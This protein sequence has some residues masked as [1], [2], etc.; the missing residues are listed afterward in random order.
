MLAAACSPPFGIGLPST[1]D[2][3]NGS[4]DGLARASGFE[5]AGRFTTAGDAYTVD[6]RYQSSG[7]A[8][9][10][11]TVAGARI[12]ALQFGATVYYH[13]REAAARFTGTDDF[14][15]AQPNAVGDRWFTTSNGALVDL[16]AFTDPVKVKANF[17]NT[18]SWTRQDHV[19]VDG[20][21]AAEL[22]SSDDILDVTESSPHRLV[23]VRTRPGRPVGAVTDG[24]LVFSHYGADFKLS[25]PQGSLN[26]DDPSGFPPFYEMKSVDI[27]GCTGDPCT[28]A[29]TVRNRAGATGA[30]KPSTVTFT[31]TNDA[32]HG[33][34]GE[35]TAGVSPDVGT[36]QSVTVRCQIA[37]GAW[38][39]FVHRGGNYTVSAQPHNPGY[40]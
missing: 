38:A 2:L 9:V 36:G 1:A 12:E 10:D 40:D 37:G 32:D 18:L 7:A 39:A 19:T 8:H 24:D 6:I 27:S 16:S 13:G 33:V 4:A 34:L 5:V 21:D 23:R 31:A 26:L 30:A 22:S 29:A 35:C 28:V 11:L 3:V 17:L 15:R 25:P 20:Q 14:G